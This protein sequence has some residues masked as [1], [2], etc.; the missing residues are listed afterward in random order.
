MILLDTCI[1]IFDALHPQKLSQK[2]TQAIDEGEKQS[3]LACCDISLWEISMLIHKKRIDPVVDTQTFL[4][5][6]LTARDI[7]VLPI[8]T[9]IAAL[10][11]EAYFNHY[12]PADRLIAS[13][14]IHHNAPLV[15]SDPHLLNISHLNVIW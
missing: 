9:S 14:A 12:D 6:I 3:L 7:T 15:T 5:L 13:T 8:D 4:N 2:A 1:L 11:S 10:S